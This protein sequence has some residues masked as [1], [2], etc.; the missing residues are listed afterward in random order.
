MDLYKI[1]NNKLEEINKESF[2]LEKDIQS[3]VENNL[4]TLFNLEFISTEFS[5]GDF[6]IDTLSYDNENNNFVIIEYKKDQVI[7]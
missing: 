4:E 7:L 5:V 6:R 2:N 3:L 1:K